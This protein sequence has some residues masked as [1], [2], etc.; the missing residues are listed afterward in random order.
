MPEQV[1]PLKCPPRLRAVAWY[2]LAVGLWSLTDEDFGFNLSLL[3]VPIALFLPT[4]SRAW[5]QIA[6]VYLIVTVAVLILVP[7][8]NLC[9]LAE[10][11]PLRFKMK[12][13]DDPVII[14]G[15]VAFWVVY[16][17][18]AVWAYRVL[19]DPEIR[20]YVAG[21][22]SSSPLAEPAKG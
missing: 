10:L 1:Q 14:A 19:R 4:G 9:G 18:L 22:S 17:A 8:A 5:H 12:T 11:G 3:G 21:R 7:L 20:A 15:V 16:V 2:F 13:S 6:K